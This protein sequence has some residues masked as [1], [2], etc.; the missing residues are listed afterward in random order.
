MKLLNTEN[1][2]QKKSGGNKNERNSISS[3]QSMN[4]KGKN[5]SQHQK[6][7][8]RQGEGKSIRA[9]MSLIISFPVIP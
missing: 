8:R 7:K 9:M 4:M 2:S 1:D 6:W 3:L 5:Y